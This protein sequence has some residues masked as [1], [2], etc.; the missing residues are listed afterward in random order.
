MHF[1]FENQ[2]WFEN[3]YRRTSSSST[4][5]QTRGWFYVL[6]TGDAL[7]D[8]RSERFSH[9]I[10][11]ARTIEDIQVPAQL[12]G[13][14]PRSSSRRPDAMRWFLMSSPILR[15]GNLIV[16]EQGIRE[17]RQV[18]LPLWNVYLFALYAN[19]ANNGEGCKRS[20]V[21]LLWA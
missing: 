5:A 14:L 13:C 12:P 7:F 6:R 11:L 1:P 3:H 2:E 8:S 4:S 10:V 9:G 17:G 19:A 18:M 16:T 15:G 21:R 20:Q